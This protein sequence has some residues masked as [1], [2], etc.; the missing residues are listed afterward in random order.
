[1]GVIERETVEHRIKEGYEVKLGSY[2]TE[3]FNIFG[4]NWG[5]Y[6]LYTLVALIMM[7]IS[8]LTVIG[9]LVIAVPTMLGFAVAADKEKETGS[10]QFSDF[11]GA[12][13][14]FGDYLLLTL[15]YIAGSVIIMLPYLFTLLPYL[16]SPER[17]GDVT[18]VFS[19]LML[20][21]FT[22]GILYIFVAVILLYLFQ[23]SLFFAPFLIHFGK[24][25]FNEAIRKSFALA[26]KNIW[27]M[28]L[29]VFISGLI[30]QLGAYICYVGLFAS[31]PIGA[32]INYSLVKNILM[33]DSFSEID[34]IGNE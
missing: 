21:S 34:Q 14:N 20:G 23:A 9:L 30:S 24:Y 22:F 31:I 27:W 5:L 10:L 18:N 7:T 28:I 6:A 29:F 19:L 32:L 11:F 17:N 2:I 26:K 13:K 25:R 12:F 16:F 33:E 4:K 15:I 8:A 3:G 1:M